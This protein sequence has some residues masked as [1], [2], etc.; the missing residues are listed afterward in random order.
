MSVKAEL[1]EHHLYSGGTY[2]N[3]PE[4]KE[5]CDNCATNIHASYKHFLEEYVP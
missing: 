1:P 3:P 5:F 2:V 4:V